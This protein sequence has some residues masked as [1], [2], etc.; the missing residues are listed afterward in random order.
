ML[1]NHDI[2]KFINSKDI[3]DYL[4]DINYQFSVPEYAYLIWQNRLFPIKERHKAFKEL[5]YSTKTC[6]LK[7]SYE[8]WN[9]HNTIKE[10]IVIE[11]KLIER[12]QSDE[13]NTFYVVEWFNHDE[14]I[15]N[16]SW[17][18]DSSYFKSYGDV[19]SH[20]LNNLEEEQIFNSIYNFRIKKKYID[21]DQNRS[22]EIIACYNQNG[23]MISI[24][25]DGKN[26]LLNDYELTIWYERFAD[27]WFD[28][29]IPFK[30]GDIVYDY[31]DKIPF[32]L[33]DT[34]PWYRKEH[35]P[36]NKSTVHLTTMDMTAS[37]YSVHKDE[38]KVRYNWLS[39]QY[40]N[41]EYCKDELEDYDRV[42]SAYSLF[43]FN[44]INGDTLSKLVQLYTYEQLAQNIFQTIDY[45][46]DEETNKKL[47]IEKY[48]ERNKYVQS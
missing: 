13:P 14:W 22:Q 38:L 44:K 23:D 18:E 39:Y 16:H 6:I 1:N 32:V 17:L 40:L 34:V 37:G 8:E 21:N 41:L 42:L 28:I 29:P 3:R 5:I 27:M 25:P 12:L 20:A 26:T 45:W 36:K 47:G 43:K 46:T 31:N 11:N 33:T 9:L 4:I 48:K 24:D 35:P 19:Y 15:K 30:P 10:Y 2:C 7:T